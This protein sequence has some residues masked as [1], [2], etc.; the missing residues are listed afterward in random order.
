MGLASKM[1]PWSVGFVGDG[2]VG[3][4]TLISN[5]CDSSWEQIMSQPSFESY[6]C[7]MNIFGKL[8]QFLLHTMGQDDFTQTR[9]AVY[10]KVQTIILCYSITSPP[11]FDSIT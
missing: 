3:K 11:S 2:A 7:E 1:E 4:T 8:N 10:S 6:A 5:L 9:V